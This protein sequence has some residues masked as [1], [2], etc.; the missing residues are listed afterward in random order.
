MN[1]LIVLTI[2]IGINLSNA[3]LNVVN[4]ENTQNVQQR[5]LNEIKPY[6]NKK[7]FEISV[8]SQHSDEWCSC[9]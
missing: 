3:D 7:N 2:L 5:K 1:L 9:G 6:K 4:Q 8:F